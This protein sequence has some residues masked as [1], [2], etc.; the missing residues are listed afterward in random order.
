MEWEDLLGLDE[1]GRSEQQE[2]RDTESLL[3]AAQDLLRGLL[4]QPEA[5]ASNLRAL[6]HQIGRRKPPARSPVGMFLADGVGRMRA[7]AT[8]GSA[9][10]P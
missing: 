1:H 2:W 9:D 4:G 8:R 3:N 7:R 10:R 5:A 6:A